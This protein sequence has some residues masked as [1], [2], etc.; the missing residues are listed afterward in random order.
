MNILSNALPK[1]KVAHSIRQSYLYKTD[2]TYNVYA[3]ISKSHPL[4][5]YYI[6]RE[7][8]T[9][10]YYTKNNLVY[11][12]VHLKQG[13]A[14]NLIPLYDYLGNNYNFILSGISYNFINHHA[15]CIVKAPSRQI[16][17][18]D[19]TYVIRL[20]SA[21]AITGNPGKSD[22]LYE[23]PHD[24]T[25]LFHSM[26]IANS[27]V[28]FLTTDNKAIFI[29]VIDLIKEETYTQKYYLEKILEKMLDKVEGDDR[30]L[31]LVEFIKS[32][33]ILEF[34]KKVTNNINKNPYDLVFYDRCVVN[35]TLSF[36]N[37][38]TSDSKTLRDI[39]SVIATYQNNELTV[40][41]Q[42]N[43]NIKVETY[44]YSY[45]IELG[46]VTVLAN[47]KYDIDNRYDIS[48]SH[49]YSVIA[50]AGDYTIISE[51]NEDWNTFV[52]YHRNEASTKFSDTH[53]IISNVGDILF[54]RAFD[55]HVV[56]AHK[57]KVIKI[58][59]MSKYHTEHDSSGVNIIDTKLVRDLLFNSIHKSGNRDSIGIDIT[60]KV[61]YVNL[62][63]KLEDMIRHYACSNGYFTV[64]PY[65]YY[66]DSDKDELYVLVH[67]SCIEM[68]DNGLPDFG[69]F[70][71]YLFRCKV[72]YLFSDNGS[73]RL[74]AR[75]EFD[76]DSY[77]PDI[78]NML[79]IDVVSG[80]Y[81]EILRL[82]FNKWY[83]GNAFTDFKIFKMYDKSN[84]YYDYKCNRRSIK[85]S[86]MDTAVKCDLHLVRRIMPMF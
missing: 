16:Y 4:K 34:D 31:E 44:F 32:S 41:F 86:L 68:I 55:K 61:K 62:K 82:L 43:S 78:S 36:D 85:A 56:F 28:L 72:S 42:M 49:L 63:D 40:S 24:V 12:Y 25:Y 83:T 53:F 84:A 19:S 77:P 67:F 22:T 80:D 30:V 71:I 51:P 38:K 11:Y 8:V 18:I 35:I 13:N 74:V 1:C 47:K 23:L 57:D 20:E 79:Y 2:K 3:Y 15:L 81:S 58:N 7:N 50:S 27:F 14:F 75:F 29:H 45:E 70:I 59:K 65:T 6:I 52:L 69:K 10:F 54:I 66:I 21:S 60:D 9:S 76:I 64:F 39:L 46:S 17:I 33:R 37:P 26:P 73:F 48:Q 5:Y